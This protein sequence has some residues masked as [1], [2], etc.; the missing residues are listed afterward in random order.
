MIAHVRKS[1]GCIQT[2]EEHLRETGEFSEKFCAVLGLE[3]VGR[4][5]GLVHDI[6]KY[7]S[8]FDEY[9]RG[10]TGL[11]GEEG[12]RDA[13]AKKGKIDHS[14]SGAQLIWKQYSRNTDISKVMAQVLSVAV[15]SHHSRTGLLDFLSLD[16]FSPFK[17]RLNRPE[18]ST[19]LNEV[20]AKIDQSILNEIRQLLADERTMKAFETL[21]Y[22]IRKPEL[23]HICQAFQC[24]LLARFIFS[25]LL[26]ADRLSTAN[27]EN[28]T[29]KDFRSTSENPDWN[30]LTDRLETELAQWKENTD[31]LS[32]LRNQISSHCREAATR[33]EMLYL[34]E[35][36]TGGGKTLASLRFALTRA[37]DHTEFRCERIIYVVPYTTIIDQNAKRV[38]AILGEEAVLEHHSNLAIERDTWKNRVL[39]ENWD[40]PVVFTTSVQFLNALFAAGTTT[41]RRMH[42]LANSVIIF[43]EVQALPVNMIH[44][45]NNAVEFITRQLKGTVMLCTATMP[46]LDRVDR[47]Y[48]ALCF[49]NAF[50]VIPCPDD[51]AQKLKRTHIR[52]ETRQEGWTVGE[53]VEFGGKKLKQTGS[54]LVVCNTKAAALKLFDAFRGELELPGLK[55]LHLSTSMCPEHRRDVISSL[56]K[57]TMN[58]LTPVVCISTQLIE[59]G[60]DLDFACVIRSLAG[61]DSIVQA[62]GRCNR[63]NQ[64]DSGDVYVINFRFE[65]L[66]GPLREIQQSQTHTRRVLQEYRDFPESLGGDL[67]SRAAMNRYYQYHFHERANEMLYQMKAGRGD[68]PLE[69]DT[70]LI[71][72]LSLNQA[73]RATAA[74]KGDIETKEMILLQGFS[75]AARSFNVIN[76][77][78]QGVLVPY[79]RGKD[80]IGELSSVL[81]RDDVPLP[82]QI[83]LLREAQSYTVNVFPNLVRQLGEKGALNEICPDSGVYYLDER[84]YDSDYLGVT[85]DALSKLE[86]MTI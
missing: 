49:Q 47:R 68:P 19:H 2:L 59:A 82:Y 16:G 9:I 38:R 84:H 37:R 32:V 70:S 79:Q 21:L 80:L 14:T 76:A 51:L 10:A 7:S 17:R 54:L 45:F 74:I 4:L 71:D 83:R 81:P 1:D 22:E 60:V 33:P 36:P 86:L 72:L 61:L 69:K 5:L 28:K 18:V 57:L 41:A 73:G 3:Q 55:V 42:Q 43:D 11:T 24:G 50:P 67:L 26:D 39:S 64:R 25:C 12:L 53:V 66:E 31:T 23:P 27:F 13:L 34:L 15:M 77:P 63:N 62:G 46:S 29:T 85:A 58:P 40:A 30:L 44:A 35:V 20:L 52:D 48:G 65:S 8:E 75:T 56:E 78:T 6:G